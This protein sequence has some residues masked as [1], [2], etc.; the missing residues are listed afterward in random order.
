MGVGYKC[1]RYQIYAPGGKYGIQDLTTVFTDFALSKLLWCE[2]YVSDFSY[3]EFGFLS[4]FA[5]YQN[6]TWL[7][8]CTVT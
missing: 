3:S 6:G 8:K 4:D 5:I 1:L 7:D 2:E